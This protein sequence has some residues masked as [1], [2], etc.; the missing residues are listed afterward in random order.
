MSS[1]VRI[2]SAAGL[3]LEDGLSRSQ[4]SIV[5]PQP[6][7]VELQERQKLWHAIHMVDLTV[8]SV[9]GSSFQVPVNVCTEYLILVRR[10]NTPSELCLLR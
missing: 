10:I 9:C 3:H 4:P 5:L 6:N 8:A 7:Q 1:V 2:A